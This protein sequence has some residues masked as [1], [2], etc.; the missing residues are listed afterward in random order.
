MQP[1]LDKETAR[2]TINHLGKAATPFLFFFDYSGTRHFVQPLTDISPDE[3]KYA[4][5]SR[6]NCPPPHRLAAPLWHVVPPA[7]ADYARA[8]GI[9]TSHLHRGNSFLVNLTARSRIETP[10]T[11]PQVFAATQ[12]PYRLWVK[13]LFTCFSPESFVKITDNEIRSFPMKGTIRATSPQALHRLM[14]NPKEA[15]EHAT[16]VDLIRNDLSIVARQV[17]VERYRYAELIPTPQ[18]GMYATSSAITGQLPPTWRRQLADVLFP[19]LPA[20]SITGAPKPC[21]C[22]I[23]AEAEA[24]D[25]GFY[26]GI[27]GIFDGQSLD[28]AVMIRFVEQT[29]RGLFFRSGGGIT[30]QSQ[31]D[32]EYNELIL[33][34]HVPF[35]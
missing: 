3:I 13:D 15:A 27:C 1:F 8:F 35:C 28:S 19:L 17:R 29:P 22:R 7:E 26:T 11:L 24:A 25:R 30:A 6:S 2:T 33:K 18:G 14:N 34:T 31:L 23:I 21:T 16:I 20:G 4:F 32:D 12:A 10:L 9:V 5:G